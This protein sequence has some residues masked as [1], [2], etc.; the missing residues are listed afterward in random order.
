MKKVNDPSEMPESIGGVSAEERETVIQKDSVSGR[1]SICTTDYSE[2]G[3]LLKKCRECPDAWKAVGYDVCEG[4]PQVGY[5][6]CPN[7]LVRYASPA[8]GR[9]F[10]DEE[11]ALLS[12]RMKAVVEDRKRERAAAKKGE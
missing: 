5:F 2:Y 8:K 7:K 4:Q 3:R 12:A 10:S 9:E 1:A 6:S 11:R